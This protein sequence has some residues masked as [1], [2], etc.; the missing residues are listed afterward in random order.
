MERS[1]VNPASSAISAHRGGSELFQPETIEAYAS[2]LE[3]G[4]EYI[5]L[6]IRRTADRKLVVYH[7]A[8]APEHSPLATTT[9]DSL[10]KL[11]GYRVPRVGDILRLIAGKALG[12]L[13]VKEIGYEH[14]IVELALATLG[15]DNFIITSLDD[16]SIATIRRGFPDVAAALS[17]GRDLRTV[18]RSA[19]IE[20]RISELFPMRRIHACGANWAALNQRLARAGAL[21][22]CHHN[23]IKAMVW[24][25][26]NDKDIAHW[27]GDRRVRVLVTDR[28][29]HA[30]SMRTSLLRRS[31]ARD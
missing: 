12:H 6:D 27:L 11:V 15:K 18:P 28:P 30:V 1:T 8:C 22:H 20:T 4:A 24:T 5:E 29:S 31:E 16:T 13:D 9:Y 23:G 26:N 3:T 7:D 2:S 10:C 19:W 17:L 21:S 14:E 25:A